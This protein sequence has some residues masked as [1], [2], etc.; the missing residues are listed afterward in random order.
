MNTH[1]S[2]WLLVA[3]TSGEAKGLAEAL[4]IP[5]PAEGEIERLIWN[6][7]EISL[8]CTG[9]GMV[10]TAFHLGRVLA[11]EDFDVALQFGIAGA[12]EGGPEV[13]EVVEVGEEIFSEMGADSPKG[14]LDLETMGFENFRREGEVYYN[15]VARPYAELGGWKSC[16]GITVN[17]V[18]GTT[19]EIEAVREK[20]SP[21]VESMEGAAFFRACLS[22]EM[23]FHQLRGISN[24]VEPRNRAAWKIPEAIKAVQ[25]AVL[26]VLEANRPKTIE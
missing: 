13:G 14:F 1:S 15:V 17:R 19:T 22:T 18:H 11:R 3:A 4:G 25:E 8:L 12:F 23:R 21:E 16:R 9:I 24:R 2:K 20:W 10:N 6:G 26:Q 7:L 5:C